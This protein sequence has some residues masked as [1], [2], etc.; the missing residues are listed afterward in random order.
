MGGKYIIRDSR[1]GSQIAMIPAHLIEPLLCL[2][3]VLTHFIAFLLFESKF[4]GA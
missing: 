4:P 1:V 3:P 2:Y